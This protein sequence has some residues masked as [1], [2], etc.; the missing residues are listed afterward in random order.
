MYALM[1]LAGDFG[2]GAGPTVVG[3]VADS[4]NG[5]LKNGLAVAMIFPIVML[6]GV[7]AVRNRNKDKEEARRSD[8]K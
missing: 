7:A 6:A 8:K 4:T 1:A 5:N 2:C 3:M